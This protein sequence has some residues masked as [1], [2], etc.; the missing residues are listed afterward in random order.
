MADK[1]Q[2]GMLRS[3]QAGEGL[4][5]RL[6]SSASWRDLVV[7]LI[8]SVISFYL[9]VK[10]NAFENMH[11]FSRQHE[12]LELD[13][14]FTLLMIVSVAL[15]VYSVRRVMDLEREVSERKQAEA[16]IRKLA[17]YDPLTGAANR[18]LLNDRL[19]HIMALARRHNS[20][21]AIIYL[22]LDGF[23]A[24]NDNL[25]HEYG[26]EVLKNVVQRLRRAVRDFDT[27]ARL[28]GDEFL[29]VLE[30][31]RGIK[32]VEQVV[33]R[34]NAVLQEPYALAGQEMR[35][36]SSIGVSIFPEHGEMCDQLIKRADIAM[37][38]AKSAGKSRVKF[39]E[40]NM[41]GLPLLQARNN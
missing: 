4:L 16:V 29:V 34:I 7:I 10:Y 13:E 25:G 32:E 9:S 28:G 23:K 8:L 15:A 26:D 41:E 14:F 6:L 39:Y 2:R 35:V 12:E 22:D 30:E 18:T 24:I 19:S 1:K 36:T 33:A 31:V 5:F 37:Y 40:T 17:H 27:V 11:E 3:D 20:M 38:R 21:L